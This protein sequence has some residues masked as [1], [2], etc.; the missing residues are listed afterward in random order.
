MTI[1]IY[2]KHSPFL[3]DDISERDDINRQIL[4]R[5]ITAFGEALR[6]LNEQKILVFFDC[7]YYPRQRNKLGSLVIKD[8]PAYPSFIVTF[9]SLQS[10]VSNL[11]DFKFIVYI[12]RGVRENENEIFKI[13]TIAHELQHLL[14]YLSSRKLYWKIPV[15]VDFL[16]LDD[17][18]SNEKYRSMPTEV[19][20]FRM[21]KKIATMLVNA[22]D[23]NAFIKKQIENSG[24]EIEKSYWENISSLNLEER[25]SWKDET[26]KLW[27]AL[28]E[29]ILA[30]VEG[31][32]KK[33]KNIGH[34]NKETNFLES[35][36]FYEHS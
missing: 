35:F 8:T 33:K 16:R 14:Q 29:E 27:I 9:P 2:Y 28:K 3:S 5:I 24:D 10:E 32:K 12:S 22:M 26:I 7:G 18:F 25:Y 36:Q 31:L 23:V 20:A 4:E 17:R 6:V 11:D 13:L 19:D 1:E 15:I 30:R 21:S 34:K